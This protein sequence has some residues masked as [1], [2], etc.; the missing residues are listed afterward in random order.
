MCGPVQGEGEAVSDLPREIASCAPARS[1]I[2]SVRSATPPRLISHQGGQAVRGDIQYGETA[3]LK[4]LGYV[5]KSERKSGLRRTA[6]LR[7]RPEPRLSVRHGDRSRIDPVAFLE[8][9]WAQ[10][11]PFS[12]PIRDSTRSQRKGGNDLI[13]HP[14]IPSRG[15]GR[16]IGC[17][18]TYSPSRFPP[19]RRGRG[20]G[21][22]IQPPLFSTISV[23]DRYTQSNGPGGLPGSG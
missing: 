2:K 9:R 1:A 18:M 13:A 3:A 12:I 22:P 5:P 6:A 21:D 7:R 4:A 23:R 15:R 17:P 10:R 19:P 11:P 8:G 16:S 20:V 14:S